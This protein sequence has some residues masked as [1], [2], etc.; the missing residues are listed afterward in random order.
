MR[1]GEAHV[2]LEWRVAMLSFIAS[3][4]GLLRWDGSVGVCC[5]GW[6][7]ADARDGEVLEMKWFSFRRC[8]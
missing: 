2:V 8:C 1:K 4:N 5:V 6:S 7:S 3:V